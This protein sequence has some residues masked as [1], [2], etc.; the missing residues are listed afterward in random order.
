ML[1][2]F[3]DP[4]APMPVRRDAVTVISRMTMNGHQANQ[5]GSCSEK[6]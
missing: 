5:V 1:T 6:G 3:N 4:S 2:L